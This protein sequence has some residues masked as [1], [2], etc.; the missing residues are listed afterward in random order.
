MWLFFVV[1]VVVFKGERGLFTVGLT[2]R[3]SKEVVQLCGSSKTG[4]RH[5]FCW[6]RTLKA[7]VTSN[8]SRI[9]GD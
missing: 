9:C 8:S 6:I 5:R 4:G 2:F 1:V 7:L 3:S